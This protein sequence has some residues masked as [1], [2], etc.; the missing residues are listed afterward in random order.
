MVSIFGK[1]V[2]IRSYVFTDIAKMI[3]RKNMSCHNVN[4]AIT[5]TKSCHNANFFVTGSTMDCH[6]DNLRCHHWQQ[7]WHD[8]KAQFS[9]N[10]CKSMLIVIC[11]D[12][13]FI[14]HDQM[15]PPM[16]NTNHTTMEW[17]IVL[18]GPRRPFLKIFNSHCPNL[19]E[20]PFCSHPCSN[21]N[22]AT[23]FCTCHDSSA[24]VTC[25]KICSAICRDWMTIKMKF[26]VYSVKNC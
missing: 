9:V 17:M 8:D 3:T 25:A 22:V 21:Q 24:V 1:F 19:M 18:A 6:N 10:L 20:I 2:S 15:L 11:V 12:L 23:I 14:L 26:P 13:W 5:E 4:F 16:H 7:S